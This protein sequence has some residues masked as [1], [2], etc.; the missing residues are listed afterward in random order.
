MPFVRML[1][2]AGAAAAF[3]LPAAAQDANPD[4]VPP[5][6]QAQQNAAPAAA[7]PVP[8]TPADLRVGAQ[9]L[10]PD[11]QPV[12]TI[13]EADGSGAVVRS[14]A[15]QG[16]LALDAFF[17]GERGIVIGYSRAEF[18]SLV[19]GGTGRGG[20]EEPEPAAP[21]TATPNPR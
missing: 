6:Q 5:S 3:A 2:A 17:K 8:A 20:P 13:A 21:A 9:V 10:G 4:P 1:L 12:G 16:R 14:A 18:D 15:G 19:G 7:G 11:G